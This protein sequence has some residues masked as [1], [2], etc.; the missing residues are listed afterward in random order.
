MSVARRTP[1]DFRRFFGT[2][3]RRVRPDRRF[4]ETVGVVIAF[5]ERQP[6]LLRSP[7]ETTEW[8]DGS[9]AK[10]GRS[11]NEGQ[12]APEALVLE[13]TIVF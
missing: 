5:V 10:A 9:F 12:L 11:G 4:E 7:H 1:I 3:V 2:T 8:H 13:Q 6:C